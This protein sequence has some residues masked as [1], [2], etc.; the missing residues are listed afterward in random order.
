VLAD[1]GDS[2]ASKGFV[3]KSTQPLKENGSFLV[4]FN[5]R[6][7]E[8]LDWAIDLR[9]VTLPSGRNLA[10]FSSTRRG[11]ATL[12]VGGQL[13]VE[14]IPVARSTIYRWV[15]P[16]SLLQPGANEVRIRIVDPADQSSAEAATSV[17]R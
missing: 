1:G 15:I 2:S 9:P 7:Q 8:A 4:R 17:T 5:V 10:E 16:E 13:A 3:I 14:S 6:L 11:L 12:T